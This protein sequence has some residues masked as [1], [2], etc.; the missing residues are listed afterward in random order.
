MRPGHNKLMEN[1]VSPQLG[2]LYIALNTT[3][4]GV[5]EGRQ[6]KNPAFLG[7]P[8]DFAVH[9]AIWLRLNRLFRLLAFPS[10]AKTAKSSGQY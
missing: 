5:C 3:I 6:Q 8:A 1:A 4:Q 2:D 7:F 9:F 10:K